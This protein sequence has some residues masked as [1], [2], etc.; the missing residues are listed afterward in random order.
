MGSH[1]INREGTRRNV[2][3]YR[4]AGGGNDSNDSNDGNDGGGTAE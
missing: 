2:K 4:E 1:E 3:K